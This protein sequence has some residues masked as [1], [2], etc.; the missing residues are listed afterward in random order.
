MSSFN[1]LFNQSKMHI[2][3]TLSAKPRMKKYG[4][5]SLYIW[6]NKILKKGGHL[7]AQVFFWGCWNRNLSTESTWFNVG[8]ILIETSTSTTRRQLHPFCHTD[9]Q[10]FNGHQRCWIHWVINQ[11]H[12]FHIKIDLHLWY[13]P[14]EYLGDGYYPPIWKRRCS[15]KCQIIPNILVGK[16]DKSRET[17]R[18]WIFHLYPSIIC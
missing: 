5:F 13:L 4:C 16:L 15:S 14:C 18:A 6:N 12:V 7:V 10:V 8:C 2:S 1:T 3:W 9:F 11:R 17:K